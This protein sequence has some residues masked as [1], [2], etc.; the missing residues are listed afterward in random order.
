METSQ[1]SPPAA[2]AREKCIQADLQLCSTHYF[3]SHFYPCHL[4]KYQI[5]SG[6]SRQIAVK[7]ARWKYWQCHCS[8]LPFS[9]FWMKYWKMNYFDL[10]IFQCCLQNRVS[11]QVIQYMAPLVGSKVLD[12]F[13]F[14]ESK[15]GCLQV[16]DQIQRQLGWAVTIYFFIWFE[17]FE[18]IAIL[19]EWR[20]GT[21]DLPESNK[22][23]P[24]S[25]RNCTHG[26]YNVTFIYLKVVIVAKDF[27]F[28]KN[29]KNF[30]S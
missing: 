9:I 30:V 24:G 15:N 11:V 2:N 27:W 4:L 3:L 23:C 19:L 20:A 26:R 7:E 5:S 10:K 18:F 21:S 17:L 28:S 13:P 25:F 16:S 14:W 12:P 22:F 6:G 8:E 29:D 1:L